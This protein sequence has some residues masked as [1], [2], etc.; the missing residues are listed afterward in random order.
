MTKKEKKMQETCDQIKNNNC[1]LSETEYMNAVEYEYKIL[2]YIP[3]QLITENIIICALKNNYGNDNLI[4]YIPLKLLTCDFILSILKIRYMYLK[5]IPE[6]IFTEQLIVD[7]MNINI[8]IVKYIPSRFK[9]DDFYKKLIDIN[10]K[11]I[12]HIEKASSALCEYVITKSCKNIEYLNEKQK[13]KLSTNMITKII[14]SNWKNIKYLPSIIITK[15]ICDLVFIKNVKSVEFIPDE[16][17]TSFMCNKAIEKDV[18]LIKFLPD[19]MLTFDIC[20]KCVE[21]KGELLEY[22]TNEEKTENL[23]LTA[24]KDNLD[25]FIYVPTTYYNNDF[26]IS[27]IKENFEFIDSIPHEYRTLDLYRMILRYY[28]YD[29]NLCDYEDDENYNSVTIIETLMRFASSIKYE[30]YD[31]EIIKMERTMKLRIIQKAY[32]DKEVSNFVVMEICYRKKEIFAFNNFKD[33]YLFLNEDVTDSYLVEYDFD[34]VNISNFNLN[35][36]HLSSKRQIQEG[37]INSELLIPISEKMKFSLGVSNQE[38]ESEMIP[39]LY[40]YDDFNLNSRHIFYITD[41]HINYHLFDKY[42]CNAS[43]AEIEFY[44]FKV[45]TKMVDNII[46]KKDDD[47]LLIGGDLSFNFEVSEIF[48]TELCKHWNPSKIIVILGNHELWD[49]NVLEG[50]CKEKDINEIIKKYELLFSRLGMKFLNNSLFVNYKFDSKILSEDEILSMS[51]RELSNI[52]L[53]SNMMVYGCI[54]FSAYND[55]FNVLNGI[56][57]NTITSIEEELLYTRKCEKVYDKLYNVFPKDKVIVLS[58][59]PIDSWTKKTPIPKWIYVSGHTHRNEFYHSEEYTLYADN[60]IGYKSRNIYLK[61][62]LINSNYDVFK[63]YKDG[64]YKI[65]RNQY[66]NFNRGKNISCNFNSDVNDIVMLKKNEMY[67]FLIEDTYKKNLYILNGGKKKELKIKNIDYYF[68]NMTY[69]VESIKENMKEF[70]HQLIE[71]AKFVKEIGGKGFIHGSIIDIDHYNHIYINPQDGSALFYFSPH[72]GIRKEYSSFAKL[73]EEQ[74]PNIYFNYEKKFNSSN[75][76]IILFNSMF[77]FTNDTGASIYKKSGIIKTLQNIYNN[78]IRIWNDNLIKN[79]DRHF[80]DDYIEPEGD[81][82]DELEK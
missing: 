15:E 79:I 38:M 80:R 30:E 24:I 72:K 64:I 25:A 51:E 82:I 56:Y 74:L 9:N 28:I 73:L 78:V 10:P 43:L 22:V 11:V 14:E 27:C 46:Y 33:F 75:N 68:N 81:V 20:R 61:Y 45:I 6:E 52:A 4:Q 67:M 29:M 12:K 44:I 31:Y 18:N 41:I 34:G 21:V 50:K 63:Y 23:C 62:F 55:R 47:F 7:A 36:A 35:G 49:L 26:F 19:S 60:Q 58:H 17:K 76:A 71:I 32:Y 39:S 5:F 57:Q 70:N 1:I 13:L 8:Q 42:N 66:I 2:S 53:K 54:G 77:D 59:M 3:K 48:Y 69:Y 37:S 65:N 16:Y 40:Y